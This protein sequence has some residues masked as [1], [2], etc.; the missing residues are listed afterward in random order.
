MATIKLTIEIDDK[1]VSS[2]TEELHP[3][4]A[5]WLSALQDS[6]SVFAL[7]GVTEAFV[8]ALPPSNGDSRRELVRTHL[9]QMATELV[10]NVSGKM[11]STLDTM[12]RG[13]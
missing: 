8:E 4:L 7:L 3:L 13:H 12:T 2:I 6:G 5:E 9:I 11:M 1:V 10:K